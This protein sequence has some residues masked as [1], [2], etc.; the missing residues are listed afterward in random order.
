MT[1]LTTS[2][3][4]GRVCLEAET[5]RWKKAAE[6]RGRASVPAA[7]A[8]E[9]TPAWAWEL[10]HG[11]KLDLHRVAVRLGVSRSDVLALVAA[12]KP[13]ADAQA[14]R[15]MAMAGEPA[16]EMV[17][18]RARESFVA[19]GTM[20]GIQ[21]PRSRTWE[22]VGQRIAA[23][24]GADHYIDGMTLWLWRP[25]S[26]MEDEQRRTAAGIRIL[27]GGDYDVL[28]GWERKLRRMSTLKAAEAMACRIVAATEEEEA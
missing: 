9:A 20:L 26:A 28:D 8:I 17:D 15:R 27:S 12:H 3:P 6:A 14:A 21:D 25:G 18:P 1:T 10:Y 13:V 2:A 4:A 22:G 16:F 19:L 7:P 11:R 5:L 24:L 23:R